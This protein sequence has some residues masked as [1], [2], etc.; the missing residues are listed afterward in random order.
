MR[1]NYKYKHRPFNGF[2][3]HPNLEQ[4]KVQWE[5][6]FGF[7]DV[8]GLFFDAKRALLFDGKALS[9]GLVYPHLWCVLEL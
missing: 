3:Q 7:T 5:M 6:P 9:S 1:V 2:S 4:L 8:T